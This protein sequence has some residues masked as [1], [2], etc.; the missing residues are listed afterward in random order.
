MFNSAT[1]SVVETRWEERYE[2]SPQELEAAMGLY[3]NLVNLL[4]CKSRSRILSSP[5]TFKFNPMNSELVMKKMTSSLERT[6]SNHERYLE[7]LDTISQKLESLFHSVGF[8]V[9]LTSAKKRGICRELSLEEYRLLSD[10]RYLLAWGLK[11][12]H[13]DVFDLRE[14]ICVLTEFLFIKNTLSYGFECEELNQIASQLM[15]KQEATFY[16]S[17]YPTDL[18]VCDRLETS[19]QAK[20]FLTCYKDRLS[21]YIFSTSEEIAKHFGSTQH[22]VFKLS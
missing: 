21:T 22:Y 13:S 16:T 5:H 19:K 9:K 20:G 3:F 4:Y 6:L 12:H 18:F 1:K 8:S 17:G 7:P 2:R 10:F 15:N 14:A 11:P